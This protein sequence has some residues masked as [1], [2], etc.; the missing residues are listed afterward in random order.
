MGFGRAGQ[1]CPAR[2]D[3]TACFA[4]A[5]GRREC[6]GHGEIFAA[7]VD[8][9]IGGTHIPNDCPDV[10]ILEPNARALGPSETQSTP[11]VV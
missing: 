4:V 9:W 10:E 8:G 2:F 7:L 11:L 5:T 1:R 6:R 3:S